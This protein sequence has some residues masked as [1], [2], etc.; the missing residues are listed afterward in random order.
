MLT[1]DVDAWEAYP[2]HRNWFNKLD[3]SLK[4]GY[5]CG[6]SGVAPPKSGDY[7]VR[8]V[9]NLIGMGV[10]AYETYIEAGNARVVEPGKFWCEKFYGPQLSVTYVWDEKW[11]QISAWEGVL[12]PGS[13]SKFVLWRKTDTRPSLPPLF[14]ALSD[15]TVLN[16]EY[17]GSNPIEVHLRASPDPD[18]WSQIVPVWADTPTNEPW[19]PAFDDGEGFLNTPRLGFIVK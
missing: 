16:V 4:M 18:G 7:I 12:A 8:P 15:V 17:I 14:D 10:G 19:V 13:L 3:F 9:Y 1:D 5:L 2:H 11:V 6:P